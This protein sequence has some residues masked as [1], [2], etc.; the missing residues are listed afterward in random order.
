MRNRSLPAWMRCAS[1]L[2]KP[3]TKE[4]F[5]GKAR[6]ETGE[7]G[8]QAR[9]PGP[10]DDEAQV[11]AGQD[12]RQDVDEQL[13]ALLGGES[14]DDPEGGHVRLPGQPGLGEQRLLADL[15]AGRVGGRVGVGDVRVALRA[16]LAVVDA[17]RDAEE[18]V[19]AGAQQGIEAEAELG[20]ADLARVGLAHR[21][22][23]RGVEDSE[24]R[25]LKRP[26]ASSLLVREPAM[27][28]EAELLEAPWPG[29]RPDRR[30]CGWSP[31]C[32][33]SRTGGPSRRRCAAAAAAARRASRGGGRRPARSPCAGRSRSPR[34][35]AGP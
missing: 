23:R 27:V 16:P 26:R 20:R 34:A 35:P 2:S 8:L 1:G 24:V 30:G 25:K 4:T 9:L 28:S 13:E 12:L 15:L 17:V 3:Q 22:D 5:S 32:G 33:C 11:A 18:V 6:F 14:R 21:G 10:D 31:G 7:E 19:G 29:R